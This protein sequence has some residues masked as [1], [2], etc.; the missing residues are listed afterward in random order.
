VNEDMT[1]DCSCG[2]VLFPTSLT[3]GDVL[4]ECANH[5]SAVVPLPKEE[6]GRRLVRNWIDKR[7]A[8]IDTQ[9]RR[10]DP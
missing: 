4:Y 2:L 9:H 5:H 1:I 8:Q 7:S 6:R 3:A 10:W